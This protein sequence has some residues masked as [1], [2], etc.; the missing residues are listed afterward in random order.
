MSQDQA[1]VFLSGARRLV[2]KARDV[3]ELKK[4]ADKAAAIAVYAKRAG[5]S[6]ELVNEA[7]EIRIRAERRAGELLSET[8]KS[9]QRDRGKGGDRKSRSQVATVKLSD[10]GVTKSQSSRW[11]AQASVP[12][13]DFEEWA[14][15][16]KAKGDELSSNALRKVA[17]EQ[18]Q[19]NRVIEIKR[20]AA[21]EEKAA[22]KDDVLKD[23][24]D[25]AGQFRCVYLDP[26]WGYDDETCRGAAEGHY[27]TMS[28]KKLSA[29]PV[30]DLAHEDGCHFWIWTTWTKIRDKAIHD[31]LDAWGLEWSGEIVWN[32]VNSGTGRWMRSL[33]E[34]LVLAIPKKGPKLPR[35]VKDQGTFFHE[36]LTEKAE[37]GNEGSHSKKPEKA[38]E[39]IERFSPGQRLELFARHARKGWRRYGF[40]A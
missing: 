40:E 34:V 13:K 20:K 22:P 5:E 15:S 17:K 37:R 19:T 7:Q 9:G 33:C 28:V 32:K 29:L 27:P 18:K 11:Q 21:V 10:A 39:L 16:T 6:L 36:A 2:E 35:L 25:G 23:L 1:L 14:V 38:Y 26:P 8:A 4:L 24:K 31:V 12:E 3:P 30:G